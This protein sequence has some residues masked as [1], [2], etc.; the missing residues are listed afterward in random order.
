M[1]GD[2][3]HEYVVE[4]I[5]RIGGFSVVRITKFR[6]DRPTRAEGFLWPEKGA[7]SLQKADNGSSYEG[8]TINLSRQNRKVGFYRLGGDEDFSEF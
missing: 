7:S 3:L 6:C 5:W 1:P 8:C 2:F 4:G